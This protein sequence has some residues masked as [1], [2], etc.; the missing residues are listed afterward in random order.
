MFGIRLKNEL[1]SMKNEIKEQ[2]LNLRTDIQNTQNV[3]TFVS[4][5]FYFEKPPPDSELPRIRERFQELMGPTTGAK[6]VTKEPKEE[7]I[8]IPSDDQFLISVRY[9]IE[10]QL[11]D[12]WQKHYGKTQGRVF[13]MGT[14]IPQLA[15]EG[16]IDP[17]F[18]NVIRDVY[19]ICSQAAHARPLT[20]KQVEFVRAVTPGVL[21]QLQENLR[22]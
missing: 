2:V 16:I 7:M 15:Q 4:P 8:K 19:S 13:P 12:I 1:E 11:T 14:I 5:Q 6:R 20:K 21:E 3:Q 22:S 17:N 10:K 18:A 9:E